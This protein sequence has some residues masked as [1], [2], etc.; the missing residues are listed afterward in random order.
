MEKLSGG[1][2]QNSNNSNGTLK[3]KEDINNEIMNAF[4]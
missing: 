3:D 2:H 4:E 1:K